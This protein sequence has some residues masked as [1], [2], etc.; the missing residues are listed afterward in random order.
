MNATNLK[1]NGTR[2]MALGL[3]LKK[4]CDWHRKDF[5]SP[6]KSSLLFF[7]LLTSILSEV[8]GHERS[9]NVALMPAATDLH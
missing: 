9:Y 4:I 6:V 1:E 5:S 2:K 8:A 3:G 7:L